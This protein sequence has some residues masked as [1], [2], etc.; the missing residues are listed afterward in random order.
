MQ[1]NKF[2]LN[3]MNDSVITLTVND[4]LS[5][6]KRS[7]VTLITSYICIVLCIV[8]STLYWYREIFE[9]AFIFA[10][11]LLVYLSALYL[12]K[13]ERIKIA[14]PILFFGVLF[15]TF[16][17]SVFIGKFFDVR[18]LYIPILI[19]P[20]LIYNIKENWMVHISVVVS[21]IVILLVYNVKYL[22]NFSKSYDIVIYNEIHYTLNILCILCMVVLSYLFQ[23]VT[24]ISENELKNLNE[25][26]THSEEE[27]IKANQLKDQL[28]QIIAHDVR[29]PL[30]SVQGVVELLKNDQLDK[31]DLELI[32]DQ[33]QK[34]ASY[35]NSMLEELLEWTN[36]Q[37]NKFEQHV[38]EFDIHSLA[39]KLFKNYQVKAE[40]KNL[41]LI[42]EGPNQMYIKTDPQLLEVIIRNLLT[43]AI[44]FSFPNNTIKIA[45]EKNP[46]TNYLLLHV[47]DNGVGIEQNKMKALFDNDMNKIKRG[48]FNEKGTGVG[49]LICKNLCNV[50][51]IQ[52]LAKSIP[53]VET[54]F[55]L[56]ISTENL[57]NTIN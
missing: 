19:I 5:D 17:L 25:K 52:I 49:L 22:P 29:S 24:S 13:K 55:T 40:E 45:I 35:T 15:H 26:L 44:K 57:K 39:E 27:L 51:D 11:F 54:R 38:I 32:A 36:S 9:L 8:F 46:L 10:F 43:N 41:S 47:I 37:S 21:L 18:A 14:K 34:T 20:F 33:F 31:K 23:Y 6:L 56:K 3:K 1:T 16:M 42:Y 48:T 28:I 50:L 7:K 12:I 30:A 53:L 2:L 4:K